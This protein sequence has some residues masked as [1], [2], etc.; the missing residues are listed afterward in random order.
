MDSV[1]R[2]TWRRLVLFPAALLLLALPAKDAFADDPTK[3][4]HGFAEAA[5]GPKLDHNGL[6]QKDDFNLLEQRLQLK[7]SWRPDQPETLARWN[8]GFFYKGGLLVDEH[9][10]NVRYNIREANGIFSPFSWL[11]VKLGRQILTW[12]TGD[13]LF[14][15]DVFPKDFESFF[16]GRDDEYLKVPSDAAKFSLYNPQVSVDLVFI[17]FFTPDTSLD[18]GRLSFYDMFLGRLAGK[19]SGRLL[20]EPP[21]QPDSTEAAA[22]V[23]RNFNGYEAALYGF[24]GYFNQAR[25]VK[26]GGNKEFFY[27]KL[28]VYG[29]SLR[30]PA[31]FVGGIVS[32]EIGYMDSLEDR[33]GIDRLVENSAVKYLAGY[34]RDFPEDLRVGVQYFVE[35]MLDFD[36]FTANAR[37]G[38]VPRDQFR[39]LMTLRLTKLFWLQTLEASCFVFYSP[40]DSDAHLRPRLAWQV[41]D[42][43]KVTVGANVFFGRSDWT[44]FGQLENNDNVYARVRYSF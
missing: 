29:S 3:N 20:K 30:G 2:N 44:E 19:E 31:P 37:A 40:T 26:S 22:R 10:E 42:Q 21:L 4:I 1:K 11:D 33:S 25:G 41:N 12:G 5:Y 9:E 39:Q 34:E 17:P 43:W 24:K 14:I 27:P 16:V 18:G 13:L 8:T 32:G 35:Q 15:N 23:Y 7:T 38:D 6:T 28:A 36:A